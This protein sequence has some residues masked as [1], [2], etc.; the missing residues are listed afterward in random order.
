[1]LRVC[2]KVRSMMKAVSLFSLA[3]GKIV[4]FVLRVLE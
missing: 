4:S 1:M 2:L 3:A